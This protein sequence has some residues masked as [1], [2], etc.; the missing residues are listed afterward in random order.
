MADVIAASVLEVRGDSSQ[1]QADMARA[2]EVAERNSQRM[3]QAAGKAGAATEDLGKR[4]ARGLGDLD[5]ASRRYSASLEREIAQLTLSRSAY[6]QWEAQTK[7][8]SETVYAPLIKRLDEAT[9]KQAEFQKGNAATANS[10]GLVGISA[11]QATAAMRGLPAQITDIVTSLQGGQKP[12]TVLIQQGGQIKDQFGG[13]G[14]AFRALATVITPVRL[15][16]AGIAGAAAAVALAYKQGSAEADEFRRSLVLTGNAAGA[17][18]AQ[19]TASAQ[20]VSAA[21]GTQGKAAEVI[22]QLAAT[23][24]V[25]AGD[26]GK[27][28]EAAIRLEREG[29]PAIKETVAA[30]AELGK[31]PTKGA[32]RLNETTN[33]LT[34]SVYKQISALQEQGRVAEAAALAQTAYADAVSERAKSLESNLGTLERAWRGVGDFAKQAWDAM[35][36]IG[37]ADTVQTQIDNIT[38]RLQQV[39]AN[40]GIGK[41]GAGFEEQQLLQQ[42]AALQELL[43][44]QNRYAESQAASARAAKDA[45][46]AEKKAA[47][48]AKQA[49][50]EREAAL[51]RAAAEAQKLVDAGAA[52]VASIEAE[53]A[54]VSADYLQRLKEIEAARKAGAIST[55]QQVAAITRLIEKQPFYVAVLKAE[56]DARKAMRA[57]REKEAKARDALLKSLDKSI[58][59]QERELQSVQD[60]IVAARFGKEALEARVNLRREEQLALLELEATRALLERGD[61][62]EYERIRARALLLQ[63]EIAARRELAGVVAENEAAEANKKAADQA[64]KDWERTADSIRSSLTD[65]FR[66]AFE[67]GEDF[68]TAMAKVI[69]NDLKSRVATALSGAL[70]DGV[71][72]V[73]GVQQAAGATGGTNG[74]LQTAQ[75]LS[76]LYGYGKSAYSFVSGASAAAAANT[77]PATTAAQA[78]FLEANGVTASTATLGSGT[79]SSG[80]ALSTW[81][82]AIAAGIYKANQDYSQGFNAGGARQVGRETFGASGTF[83]ALQNDLLKSLGVSDRLASLLSG[84]TAVAKILGRAAPRAE[85]AGFQ[86]SI[87]GGDFT[88]QGF[89]D[90]VEKGGLLRSDKRYTQTSALADELGRFLDDA[91]RSVFDKA[92]EF[93][94]ALGLP[95]EALAS[96][97]QDI[98]V[99]LT[100]DAE[101]NSRAI[102]EA[103]AGYGDALVAGYAEAIKPLAQYG[104]TTV[105]TI[106]RVGAAIVGVNEVLD[107]LGVTALQASIDGG[108]A[109]LALQDIFGGLQGLQQAA[110]SYLQAYYTDAERAALATQSVGK[111]L[112]DFGLDV[113]ATREAF[114]A[115]VDAQD[116]TAESGRQAFAALLS[117][118][119]VMDDVYKGFDDAATAAQDAAAAAAEAAAELRDALS[120]AIADALPK[121]QS[122]TEQA[123]S[124][125]DRIAGNLQA[126]GV[127]QGADLSAVLQGA[128][129]D[130]IFA[131]ARAFVELGSNTDEAKLA[132]VEAA[133][134]LAD[135]KDAATE[136]AADS[137]R[138]R[139]QDITDAFGDLSVI[140]PQALNLSQQFVQNANSIKTLEDGLASLLGTVGR[141]VQDVLAD[142]LQSQRALQSVRASLADAIDEARLRGLTPEARVAALRGQESS[143][144]GQLQTAADPAAVAQRLQAVIVARIKE[145]AGIRQAAADG[146]VQALQLQEDLARKARDAQI[147]A[148]REQISGAERL[149][150]LSKNIGQFTASLRFG[151]LSPADFASQLEAARSLFDSTLAGAR[152]GDEFAQSNLITNAQA[153]LQEAASFA[154]VGTEQY[155]SI[156]RAVTSALDE[157]GATGANVDPQL[158][159]LNAQLEALQAL[160][161]RQADFAAAVIDTSAEE[162]AALSALDEALAKREE[163]AQRAIAEQT[164]LAREQIEQIKLT[165]EELRAQIAQQAAMQAELLAELDRL[166][167]GGTEGRLAGTMPAARAI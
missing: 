1:F 118:A 88:G 103:L 148:L 157:F 21:V 75:S 28:A 44:I 107:A 147:D 115:L 116:L 87:A 84:A 57:E 158:A 26:L 4:G 41:F 129:K 126:A 67:S 19:L 71:L 29:G 34:A 109:A 140:D 47:E 113:P 150:E 8:I 42:Q 13:I 99:K 133:S 11:G 78:A 139:I 101:A 89:V 81:A 128:S 69:E 143:L 120:S 59:A 90:I 6:R 55:E 160:N 134:A 108:Q 85:A 132:V 131:F 105:Q 54:G 127:L 106:E 136:L 72:S 35:L 36:N 97:T 100:D 82:A 61:A 27:L 18:V 17:T 119:G 43:R 153:Y 141:S 3:V 62:E 51:K 60:Q 40:S 94:Q 53:A 7:G 166:L 149:A 98:K 15:A 114:R 16:F 152:A 102:T 48:E 92:T 63:Q 12:L 83:E 80:V 93:G 64:A 135:L 145:E 167:S 123:L 49:A 30:F 96:L 37:R 25:A 161:D 122:P 104:E 50:R 142:L 125:Y 65:A 20:A 2:A 32:E 22:A 121:F 5:S 74:Y 117:V 10:L 86:G 146:A 144:F 77:V 79:A 165:N 38:K 66:R 110:G 14:N 56:E 39:R 159:A 23:G 91:A 46:G 24:R 76:T 45:I 73:L 70:A 124:Q 138:Q 151:D 31:D 154:P 112:A 137:L 164:D 155:A 162:V 163:A 68:G 58:E 156:F 33:F 95:V 9:K 111:A 130:D 52:F